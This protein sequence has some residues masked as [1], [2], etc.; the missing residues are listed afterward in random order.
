MGTSVI[1]VVNDPS[2]SSGK[3]GAWDEEAMLSVQLG[4][5]RGQDGGF[6]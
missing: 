1:R 5:S 3:G 4:A 6:D 2:E